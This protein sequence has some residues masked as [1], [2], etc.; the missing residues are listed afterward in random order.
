MSA[1]RKPDGQNYFLKLELVRF[2]LPRR[3]YTQAHMDVVAELA[4]AVF[5][6]RKKIKGLRWFMSRSI[7]GFSRP[8][9]KEIMN[10]NRMYS[11]YQ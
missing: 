4:A 7:C 9:L 3:V 10:L 6:K 11:A 2:T 5:E 8:D 1:G